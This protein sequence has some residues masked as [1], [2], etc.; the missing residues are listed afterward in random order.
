MQESWRRRE[1]RE[2]GSYFLVGRFSAQSVADVKKKKERNR[3]LFHRDFTVKTIF[4]CVTLTQGYRM[5]SCCHLQGVV[6]NHYY[7]E[8]RL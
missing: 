3:E 2:F 4:M 8:S 6:W 7:A 1:T 5:N